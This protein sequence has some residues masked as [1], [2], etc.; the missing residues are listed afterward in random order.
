MPKL[1][2][3]LPPPRLPHKIQ[4]A[5]FVAIAYRLYSEYGCASSGNGR[6]VKKLMSAEI[7]DQPSILPSS[8]ISDMDMDD[9]DHMK[10]DEAASCRDLMQEVASRLSV[11]S[12]TI[13]SSNTN[14]ISSQGKSNP[15]CVGILLKIVS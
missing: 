6:Q 5:E 9:E 8:R 10:N 13:N 15:F 12:F 4:S 1:L 11:L 7:K 3:T 2:L 14:S